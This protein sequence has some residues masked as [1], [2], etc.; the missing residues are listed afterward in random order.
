[1]K[2]LKKLAEVLPKDVTALFS[3]M[4]KEMHKKV[5]ETRDAY[6]GFIFPISLDDFRG[7]SSVFQLNADTTKELLKAGRS[8]SSFKKV[9]RGTATLTNHIYG[10]S[11]LTLR[12]RDLN[13]G[14]ADVTDKNIAEYVSKNEHIVMDIAEIRSS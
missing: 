11:I 10:A 1:M 7:I 12:G 14:L 4:E 2:N 9:G 3:S 13:T 5:D 6:F 8:F